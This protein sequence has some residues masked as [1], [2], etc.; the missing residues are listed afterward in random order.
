M[1]DD[2]GGQAKREV[3]AMT[4]AVDLGGA[5]LALPGPG[6]ALPTTPSKRAARPARK[7]PSL[8]NDDVF[9]LFW[10]SRLVS[11]TAQGALAYAL[12]IILVD[13]T[14]ASFFNSLYV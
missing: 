6:G 9:F 10:L 7:Q 13:R 5:A 3:Q 14:D 12:L 1:S 4:Q 2:V 11:Q 8:L